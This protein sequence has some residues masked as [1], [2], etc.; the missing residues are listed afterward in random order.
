MIVEQL[1]E[2]LQQMDPADHVLVAGEA[3]T[4]W[5]LS[6]VTTDDNATCAILLVGKEFTPDQPNGDPPVKP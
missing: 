1:I 6:D 4:V 3:D 2:K 5:S